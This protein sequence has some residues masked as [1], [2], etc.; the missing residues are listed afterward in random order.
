MQWTGENIE[1]V[2]EFMLPHKPTYMAEFENA[3]EIL[4]LPGGVANKGDWIVRRPDGAREIWPIAADAFDATYE[5]AG[6]KDQ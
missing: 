2:F 1:A 5:S 6:G 3:D 4:G